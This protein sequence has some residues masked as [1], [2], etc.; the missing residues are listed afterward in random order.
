[1]RVRQMRIG[2]SATIDID[3]NQTDT[4]PITVYDGPIQSFLIEPLNGI[5][6]PS[7]LYGK[8]WTGGPYVVIRYYQSAL[9]NFQVIPICAEAR[10]ANNLPLK[11]R[12][13]SRPG[14]AVLDYSM[15]L[16]YV[17]DSFRSEADR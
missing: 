15:A 3:V 6:S 11:K 4:S 14:T 13:N 8:V 2:Q 9:D 10:L 5:H 7:W 1:M 16:V 17:V 12:P